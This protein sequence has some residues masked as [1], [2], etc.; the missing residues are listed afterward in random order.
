VL[1]ASSELALI[2][3]LKLHPEL[4]W[5]AIL[6]ATVANTAGGMTTYLLGRAAGFKK[7]LKEIAWAER[8]GAKTMLG[9]WLPVIGDGLVFAAGWLKLEWR[10]VLG[11]QALGRLARYLVVA[12]GV[13]GLS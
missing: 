1:P 2:A 10:A 9:A 4:E 11:Y 13:F 6:V 5:P 7:P 3:L 12:W 8:Y